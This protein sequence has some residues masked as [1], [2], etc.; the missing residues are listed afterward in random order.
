MRSARRVSQF[1]GRTALESLL[2]LLLSERTGID[3]ARRKS[4][5]LAAAAVR[6]KLQRRLPAR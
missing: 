2:A 1:D 4:P 6:D 5:N 3:D